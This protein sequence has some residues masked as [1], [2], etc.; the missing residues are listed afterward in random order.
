MPVESFGRAATAPEDLRLNGQHIAVFLRI[1]RFGQLLLKRFQ[2]PLDQGLIL[3]VGN[4]GET[5]HRRH[6]PRYLEEYV[7]ACLPLEADVV[8][9]RLEHR[10]RGTDRDNTADCR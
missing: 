9:T 4:V 2:G 8:M 7:D 5:Q 6:L 3:R 1:T 10:I